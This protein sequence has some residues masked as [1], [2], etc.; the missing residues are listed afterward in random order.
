MMLLN[1]GPP[2]APAELRTP[3]GVSEADPHVSPFAAA[4]E[5]ADAPAGS[6]V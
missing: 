3:R 6:Q 5:P 1:L 2:A 4:W